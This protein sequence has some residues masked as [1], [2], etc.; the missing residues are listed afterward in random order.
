MCIL[1]VMEDNLSPVLLV[2]KP[3]Q[4]VS[5]NYSQDYCTMF[6]KGK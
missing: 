6:S 1:V 3:K 5:F 4:A 2:L